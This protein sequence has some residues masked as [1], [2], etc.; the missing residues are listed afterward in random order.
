MFPTLHFSLSLSPSLNGLRSFFITL[1]C[2]F[3]YVILL[4][5]LYCLHDA[6]S[7]ARRIFFVPRLCYY[8]GVLFLFLFFFFLP[9]FA[10]PSLSHWLVRIILTTFSPQQIQSPV[11]IVPLEALE[12]PHLSSFLSFSLSIQ[13]TRWVVTMKKKWFVFASFS[14]QCHFMSILYSAVV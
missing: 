4:I 12:W 5:D 1:L 11:T 8:V 14:S 7:F 13:L 3:M 6:P 10:S 9:F 2:I